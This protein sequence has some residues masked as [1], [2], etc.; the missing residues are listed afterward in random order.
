MMRIWG[1]GMS[2]K[3]KL[4]MWMSNPRRSRKSR[5]F[6]KRSNQSKENITRIMRQRFSL[7]RREER[8]LGLRCLAIRRK[9][10]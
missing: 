4:R 5:R 2:G 3:S 6:R 9:R 10:K 1:D 8:G 7:Q